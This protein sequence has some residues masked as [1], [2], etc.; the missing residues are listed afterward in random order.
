[1]PLTRI[2]A[3]HIENSRIILT[4][5]WFLTLRSPAVSYVSELYEWREVGGLMWDSLPV[6]ARR[7]VT[8]FARGV[9]GR[10][11]WDWEQDEKERERENK[12]KTKTRGS[13]R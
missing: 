5:P 6:F 11:A 9:N 2:A 10:R 7:A 12:G 13:L 4:C 1:V 8:A 3:A